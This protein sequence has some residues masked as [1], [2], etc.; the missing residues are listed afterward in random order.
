MQV[1]KYFLDSIN[2]L[3]SRDELGSAIQLL[4]DLLKDSPVLEEALL[5][6]ARYTDVMKQIRLGTIDYEQAN[7]TKNKIRYAL[8]DLVREIETRKA[9]PEIKL[10]V[11]KHFNKQKSEYDLFVNDIQQ[12]QHNQFSTTSM[13]L[14]GKTVEQLDKKAVKKL[15]A[16]KRVKT[17]FAIHKIKNNTDT[18]QKLKALNLMTNGY[19]LK[20]TFLCL[21]SM[22]QI[23]SVSQN[24]NTSKFFVFEDK[25]GLR[26]AITEFVSGNLIE[27]FEQMLTHIKRN[28]YLIRNI[29]TRT[30]DYEIPEKVFTE[31]LANAFVHRKYEPD[32]LTDIKVEIY[33]DRMEISNPGQFAENIDLKNIIDNNKSFIINPEIVQVFFLN[34]YVE[35]AAKGI[36]RSQEALMSYGLPLATFEQKNG[37]VK[38]VIEKT[39]KQKN[40]EILDSAYKLIGEKDIAAYFALMET[41]TDNPILNNLQQEFIAGS[42]DDLF[43][44]R[45][46]VFTA[47]VLKKNMP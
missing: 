45:L 8:L 32:V 15:F 30:E 13:P 16:Q 34:N 39:K 9:L 14:I 47:S 23:R 44:N 36:K 37:Y 21:A 25:Q 41:Q 35:T 20:G 19:V 40:S 46:K 5:H 11:E 1:S 6:S 26:T 38:V 42:V 2:D 4:H 24:A 7:I 28:I 3:I 17:H 18:N 12:Y 33:P 22:D 29:D 27:Q 31:L 43:F 10:E